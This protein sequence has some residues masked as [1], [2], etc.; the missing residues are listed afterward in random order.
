M[1][2]LK[3]ELKG[4]KKNE[5]PE[6]KQNRIK[7]L[8]GTNNRFFEASSRTQTAPQIMLYNGNIRTATLRTS[9][10]DANSELGQ[11]LSMSLNSSIPMSLSSGIPLVRG[12][13]PYS[14]I[15]RIDDTPYTSNIS[16]NNDHG[17]EESSTYEDTDYKGYNNSS[18]ITPSLKNNVITNEKIPISEKSLKKS[19]YKVKSNLKPIEKKRENP[20]Q[21][22]FANLIN[23]ENN[24][25]KTVN[26]YDEIIKTGDD[27]I[28][29]KFLP[30]MQHFLSKTKD[31]VE[32][33]RNEVKRKKKKKDKVEI[34]HDCNDDNEGMN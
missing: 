3:E 16:N 27:S 31:L 18:I 19:P 29:E 5:S 7:K 14:N 32:I 24:K 23:S 1:A 15:N 30:S 33:T 20:F 28:K 4:N 17:F 2:S 13:T 8:D 25:S 9:N 11:S 26:R 10:Y 22:S 21:K 12:M 34:V 6:F